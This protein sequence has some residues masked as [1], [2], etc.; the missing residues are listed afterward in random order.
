[1]NT[2]KIDRRVRRTKTLLTQGLMQLMEE[3]DIRDISVRELSDLAD[4]NR[5]TFYLHYKDIYDL[6]DKIEDEL[7]T[8][9]NGII[10]RHL[11]SDFQVL[12]PQSTLEDIF[13]FL[14]KHREVAR[15]MVG[16]H[17]DLAFVNRLKNLVKEHMDSIAVLRDSA[18]EYVYTEA[19][20][21]SGCI[22]VIETWLN[23][24]TPRSPKEMAAYCSDFLIKG[25]T[26][27]Q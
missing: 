17:G 18:C 3:K 14:E 19:F 5:G 9:F 26:A 12:A 4:I 24:P 8:E 1:M 21:V 10:N 16:P 25:L 15:V 27:V 13:T 23:H 20:I 11:T 2:E 7:F 22:G 6:L